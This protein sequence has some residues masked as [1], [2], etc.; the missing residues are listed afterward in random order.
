MRHKLFICSGLIAFATA[1]A[2]AQQP[3][4][5]TSFSVRFLDSYRDIGASRETKIVGAVVDIKHA[6]VKNVHVQLRNLATGV[7]EQQGTS[8]E[9]GTYE[10]ILRESGTYVVEMVLGDSSVVAL[11]EA[12]LIEPFETV[13][14]LVQLPGRWDSRLQRIDLSPNPAAYLGVSGQLSMTAETLELAVEMNIAPKD[15]GEP[16]SP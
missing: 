8:N 1:A 15:A 11:S 4:G 14:T 7:V 5:A 16:V 12:R 6:Q 9:Y 13:W 3:Q 10:F 2:V